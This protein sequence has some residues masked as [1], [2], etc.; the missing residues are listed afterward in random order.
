MQQQAPFIFFLAPSPSLTSHVGPG[1]S[2]GSKYKLIAP[3]APQERVY[4]PWIGGSILGSLGSFQQ[5]WI[6]RSEYDDYGK[7][8]LEKKCQ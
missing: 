2:Q 5:M 8:V 7:V 1:L 6:S 3:S 4:G